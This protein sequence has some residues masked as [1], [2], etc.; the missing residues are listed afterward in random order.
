MSA[1]TASDNITRRIAEVTRPV[2]VQAA[3]EK[4]VPKTWEEE[5]LAQ[6]EP[7]RSVAVEIKRREDAKAAFLVRQISLQWN[8]ICEVIAIRCECINARAA[9]TVLRIASADPNRLEFR[10]EDDQGVTLQFEPQNGKLS[11]SGKA[12]GF[13][14]NYELTV[15]TR[16]GVDSTAWFSRT[17]LA[18]EETDELSKSMISTL[19]RFDQ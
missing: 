15:V 4:K 13:D 12:L 10:R 5:E 2:S 17:T 19:M 7:K 11:F 9:R 16:D 3:P 14:R 6:Y 8:A 18:T 1:Q